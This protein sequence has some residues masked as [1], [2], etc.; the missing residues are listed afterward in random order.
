MLVALSSYS[1]L[2]AGTPVPV[3]RLL[4]AVAYRRLA[5]AAAVVAAAVV[6]SKAGSATLQHSRRFCSWHCDIIPMCT[7]YTRT[8]LAHNI[9]FSSLLAFCQWEGQDGCMQSGMQPT[10]PAPLLAHHGRILSLYRNET[11]LSTLCETP[12]KPHATTHAGQRHDAAQGPDRS[13]LPRCTVVAQGV[14]RRDT[15]C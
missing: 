14:W 6:A 11:A 10:S 13:Q 2:A 15:A 9:T 3:L 8:G 5:D 1:A 12:G 4:S 7:G